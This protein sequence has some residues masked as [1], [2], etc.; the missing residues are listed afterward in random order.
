MTSVEGFV[1]MKAK[2]ALILM[3]LLAFLLFLTAVWM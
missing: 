2:L 1:P 3:G